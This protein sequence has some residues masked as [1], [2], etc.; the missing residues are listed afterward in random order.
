MGRH[1]LDLSAFLKE[2][3]IDRDVVFD[4]HRVFLPLLHNSKG[5]Q[6][7]KRFELVS[8]ECL[9]LKM[10][11]A[12]EGNNDVVQVLS[13]YSEDGWRVVAVKKDEER[14]SGHKAWVAR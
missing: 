9:L 7:M 14:W 5:N 8:F 6:A 13:H 11:G 1:V 10:A 4:T 12:I 2:L 3:K